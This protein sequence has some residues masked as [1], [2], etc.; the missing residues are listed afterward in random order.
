MSHCV[1]GRLEGDIARLEANKDAF[2]EQRDDVEVRGGV[3]YPVP[4]P[5]FAAHRPLSFPVLGVVL[6]R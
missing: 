5:Y 2:E 4:V 1:V 6:M 3:T